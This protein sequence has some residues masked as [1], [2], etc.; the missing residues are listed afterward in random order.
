MPKVPAVAL[1]QPFVAALMV[2]D[3]ESLAGVIVIKPDDPLR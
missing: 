2:P 1:L 3:P